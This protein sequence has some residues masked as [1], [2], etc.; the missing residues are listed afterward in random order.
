MKK[1]I[2]ALISYSIAL[3]IVVEVLGVLIQPQYHKFYTKHPFAAFLSILFSII[4]TAI[5]YFLF[6]LI[7]KHNVLKMGSDDKKYLATM[8]ASIVA[9]LGVVF[10]TTYL[11]MI[12]FI[13]LVF[14][15]GG[16]T[17]G[18]IYGLMPIYASIVMVLSYGFGYIIGYIISKIKGTIKLTC[19]R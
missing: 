13:S 14:K 19:P 8:T 6:S 7:L 18:I 16:S 2:V 1:V 4:T 5:P 12:Y 10:S 9:A 15:G 3:P 11:N 17:S